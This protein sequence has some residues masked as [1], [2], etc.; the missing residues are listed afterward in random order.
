MAAQ[1]RCV[2][3][4]MRGVATAPQGS[5]G[6]NRQ[7]LYTKR[8]CTDRV[9]AGTALAG[10]S[11]PDNRAHDQQGPGR[12]AFPAD[13]PR[14]LNTTLVPPRFGAFRLAIY[15]P[16]LWVAAGHCPPPVACTATGAR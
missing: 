14:P 3:L 12:H 2:L 16:D 11:C 6:Q 10:H 1:K 13:L 9:R 15:P 5:S 4:R 7:A 8:T